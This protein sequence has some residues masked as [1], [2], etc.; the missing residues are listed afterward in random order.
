MLT[1]THSEVTAITKRQRYAA[2]KKQLARMGIEYKE[3]ADGEPIVS[4]LAFEKS[5]GVSSNDAEQKLNLNFLG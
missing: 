4:R 5:F 2:Q 3:A 1:L